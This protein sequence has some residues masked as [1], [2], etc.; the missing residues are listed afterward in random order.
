MELN[1]EKLRTLIHQIVRT[2]GMDPVAEISNPSRIWVDGDCR[3]TIPEDM[4][5]C[6]V[7]EFDDDMNPHESADI[8]MRFCK[9][10]D[11]IGVEVMVATK[12]DD[13]Y[14]MYDSSSMIIDVPMDL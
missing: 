3:V 10:L 5:S 1:Q 14:G 8:A 4:P 12:F 11:L 9:I 7:I 2:M 6:V 13:L